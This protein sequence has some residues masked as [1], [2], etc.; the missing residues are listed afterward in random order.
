MTQVHRTE[1]RL[2]EVDIHKD[3]SSALLSP[4]PRSGASNKITESVTRKTEGNSM[5]EYLSS[6][7]AKGKFPKSHSHR[8]MI[9]EGFSAHNT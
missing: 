2:Q 9:Q 1:P 5:S 4:R 8:P 3:P 6:P 7:K